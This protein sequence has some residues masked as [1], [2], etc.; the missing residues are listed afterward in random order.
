MNIHENVKYVCEKCE[1]KAR[2][3]SSLIRHIMSLHGGNKYLCSKCDSKF[4]TKSYLIYH[5]M[6]I[7]VKNVT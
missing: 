2:Q 6:S 4:S 5:E 7:L 3:Q 1:Y